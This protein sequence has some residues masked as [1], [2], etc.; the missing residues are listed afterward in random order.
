MSLWIEME[1]ELKSYRG[2]NLKA[3]EEARQAG[4]NGLNID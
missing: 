2:N 4:N 1:T 3:S